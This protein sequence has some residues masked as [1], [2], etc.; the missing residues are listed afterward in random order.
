[1]PVPASP[2]GLGL[3]S[4]SEWRPGQRETVERVL[5]AF[6]KGKK[7]VILEAPT[8]SGKSLIAAA[9]AKSLGL[10]TMILTQTKQLG[11]QY[12]DSFDFIIVTFIKFVFG[13]F[14]HLLNYDLNVSA[15]TFT[16]PTS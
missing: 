15:G 10:T 2:S 1:M 12:I 8:G 16:N 4:F 7:T 5:A 13:F 6:L 11:Q 9:V 3:T 14:Q